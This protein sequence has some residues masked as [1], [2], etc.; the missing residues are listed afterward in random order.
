IRGS[1]LVDKYI[2]FFKQR[3][4]GVVGP[5]EAT[6]GDLMKNRMKRIPLLVRRGD[7]PRK[8]N[9]AK[10]PYRAQTGWSLTPTV[11]RKRPP[12]LRRVRWLRRNLL[13]ATATPPLEEGN[14]LLDKRSLDLLYIGHRG[15][16][17]PN[18]Q[19]EVIR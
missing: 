4:I 18:W 16:N 6:S 3:K 14:E 2:N 13:N 10:P 11:T 9:G 1:T 8:K 15:E 7:A 12:R 17:A 5:F 19:F